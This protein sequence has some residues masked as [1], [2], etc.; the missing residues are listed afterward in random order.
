[1]GESY[2]GRCREGWV[3]LVPA[4]EPAPAQ[5]VTE[6]VIV[7]QDDPVEPVDTESVEATSN[8]VVEAA[9]VE[10]VVEAPRPEEKKEEQ[11][12]QKPGRKTK[13]SQQ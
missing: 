1:M 13:K 10:T 5:P 6:E 3:P 2:F 11:A 7:P 4:A 9:V 8:P 12:E